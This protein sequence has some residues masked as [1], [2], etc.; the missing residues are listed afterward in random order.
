MINN[1][2]TLIKSITTILFIV[3]FKSRY[4]DIRDS[5][6]DTVEA[7]NITSTELYA[8]GLDYEAC[9]K[10]AVEQIGELDLADLW[11]ESVSIPVKLTLVK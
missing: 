4:R 1:R 9:R 11:L 8:G 2:D 10:L 5:L 7:Y 6:W 3:G